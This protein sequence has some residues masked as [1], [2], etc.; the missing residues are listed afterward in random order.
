MMPNGGG[1][2]RH[3]LAEVVKAEK[4]FDI[5]ADI[6]LAEIVKQISCPISLLVRLYAEGG[7]I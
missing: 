3:Y 1:P 2:I 7:G 6:D 4:D 5:E